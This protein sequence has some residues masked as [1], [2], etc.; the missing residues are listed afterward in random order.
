MREIRRRVG[1][2]GLVVAFLFTFLFVLILPHYWIGAQ[3]PPKPKEEKPVEFKPKWG[4]YIEALYL[5]DSS[6][7]GDT[8]IDSYFKLRRARIGAS[9]SVNELISYK[10]VGAFEGDKAQLW[11]A[12]MDLKFHP[13]FTLTAGQFKY[14]FTIEGLE[15]TP[16]RLPVLRAESINAIAGKLGTQGGS[17]RDI[18]IQIKGEQKEALGLKYAIAFIN[19]N[20]I[21]KSLATPIDNNNAKDIVARVDVSPIEGLLLGVSGYSGSGENEEAT[22]S[23]DETAYGAHAEYSIKDMGL[24]FR[25]EYV[26]A[27]YEN[28]K[29]KSATA[30]T[31]T[32][33]VDWKPNGWYLQA[34]YKVPPLPAL[35]LLLRY[36]QFEVDSNT[37]DSNLDSI[38]LGALYNFTG[39]T[40]FRVN[41]I[42]RDAGESSIVTAQETGATATTGTSGTTYP[43][44]TGTDIDNLII[45]QLLVSF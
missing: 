31:P 4:G 40:N 3:E 29:P 2:G 18:G 45:A 25:G 30:C 22:I 24:R 41:Y 9:G 16:D 42:I 7:L 43:V 13:L 35:E 36:E 14:P 1:V 12:S 20:G 8:G 19:G 17:L 38:T 27:T 32:S 6:E 10:I 33:E 34:G 39:K 11:D 15:G 44:P 37:S 28:C 21:N 23:I 26:T 5:N